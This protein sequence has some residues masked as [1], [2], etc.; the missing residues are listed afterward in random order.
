[1]IGEYMDDS[2]DLRIHYGICTMYISTCQ[3]QALP[4]NQLV[5]QQ[6]NTSWLDF[7]LFLVAN[8]HSPG[9]RFPQDKLIDNRYIPLSFHI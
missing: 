7:L 8:E 9:S 2:T 4:A 1:M 6:A 5:K 3:N